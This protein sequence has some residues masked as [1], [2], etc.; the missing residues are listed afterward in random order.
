MV[1]VNFA[2]DLLGGRLV[3]GDKTITAICFEVGFRNLADFNREFRRI[4]SMAPRQYR[5]LLAGETETPD[6]ET[7]GIDPEGSGWARAIGPR[8]RVGP[9][10][11]Y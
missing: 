6:G 10:L 1:V 3:A 11:N 4:T 9:G 5:R 2:H 7:A 8:A